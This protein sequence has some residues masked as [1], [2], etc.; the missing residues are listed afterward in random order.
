[1]SVG[2]EGA[3]GGDTVGGRVR[4]PLRVAV[5]MGG[6]SEERGVS[7]ASGCEVAAA[8]RSR[9]HRV[10][11]IDAAVGRVAPALERRVLESG[12]GRAGVPDPPPGPE[13]VLP[14][15][16]VIASEPALREV[17]VVFVALHGGAGEDGT[18]Q[19][20]L[21][22]AGIPYA[23]SGPVACALAMDKDL[24]KRLFRDAGVA[25]PDWIAGAAP[26]AKVVERLGLPVI[27]KP[28]SGGSS[29]RLALARSAAEVD[30]ATEVAGGGGDVVMYEAYVEGREF[31]VGIVGEETLPVVEIEPAGELFDFDSKYEPGMAVETVP[32]RIPGELAGELR[33]EALRVHRLLR[34][35]HF[36][37]VDF[38][39]DADGGVWCLE[40]NALPGLTSNS[41]LPKAAAAAGVEFP[42]L[43]ERICLLG[44]R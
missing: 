17:E 32:A 1:M 18:I 27:V 37:R 4:G 11:S 39:V 2:A 16:A 41:L 26:G 5:L 21:E 12:I 40:A 29:V 10:T 42:D 15:A 3:A 8:L 13:G 14:E 38:M 23:G 7:L 19:R 34:M 30:A 6:S 35:Q 31:T 33:A 9:G 24:T 20:L 22:V 36:S 25:T 44:R 43:C 28:M